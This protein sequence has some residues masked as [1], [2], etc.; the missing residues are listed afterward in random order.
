MFLDPRG[1]VYAK[2][3][4]EFPPDPV[5][6][7]LRDMIGEYDAQGLIDRTLLPVVPIAEPEGV[8]RLIYKHVTLTG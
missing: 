5:R 2:H 7:L 1:Y 4:G 6:E 8:L 3:E